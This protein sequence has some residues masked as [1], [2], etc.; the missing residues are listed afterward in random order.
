[1]FS[2]ASTQEFAPGGNEWFCLLSVSHNVL[3]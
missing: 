1:M 2:V 3:L